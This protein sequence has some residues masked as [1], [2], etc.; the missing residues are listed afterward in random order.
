MTKLKRDYT[1]IKVKMRNNSHKK[2]KKINKTKKKKKPN[3]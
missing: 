2:T 3:I 1:K